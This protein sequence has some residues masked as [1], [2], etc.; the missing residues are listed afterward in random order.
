[1]SRRIAIACIAAL[2]GAFL[3]YRGTTAGKTAGP[4]GAEE[5]LTVDTALAVVQPMPVSLEFA[6]QVV[7]EHMVQIRPQVSGVLKQVFI[8]EGQRVSVGQR[9]FLIEPAPF[10]AA[11]AAAKAA[12]ESADGKLQRA[13]PLAKQGY[14]SSQD[15]MAARSIADQA[16]AAYRQAVINLGYTDIRS[17]LA[18]QTGVLGLKSGNVVTPADATPLV[19]INQ[20]RPIQVQFN[21]PQQSLSAVRKH[22]T[23]HSIKI[24]VTTDDSARTLDE[25]ALIFVDNQVN[26]SSGTILL[27]ARTPNAQEQLWPG[28]Y[29]AVRMELDVEPRAIVVPQTAVET[30]QN[31]NFLYVVAEGR[32]QS[33]GVTVDRD[34]GTLAVISKGLDGHEQIVVRVPRGL[35]SGSRV[36]P[37]SAEPRR[38]V[39]LSLP[40]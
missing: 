23:E 13:E 26:L 14:V 20:T 16:R 1:V 8:T 3:I 31:G 6:A 30:G 7:A 33:R 28:E 39:P 9:L 21:I 36:E 40:R 27:K 32:A 11:A 18:G 38:E 12:W 29:V 4:T 34:V 22:Q 19:T 5:V 37:H 25:G 15:L 35:H 10:E 24:V 2:L 17:P